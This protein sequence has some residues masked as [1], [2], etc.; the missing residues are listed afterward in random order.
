MF[1]AYPLTTS[2]KVLLVLDPWV[3]QPRKAFLSSMSTGVVTNI[4]TVSL[5]NSI[6]LASWIIS[7]K[8]TAVDED[9]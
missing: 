6:F 7:G 8:V 5:T 9:I 4:L 3:R 1:F 2:I